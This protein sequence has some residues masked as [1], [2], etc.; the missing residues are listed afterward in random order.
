MIGWK[1]Y[2]STVELEVDKAYLVTNGHAVDIAFY[3]DSGYMGNKFYPPDR[4]ALDH[5]DITYYAEINLPEEER[6]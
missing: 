5:E 4:S 1:K 6:A 2:N 3:M